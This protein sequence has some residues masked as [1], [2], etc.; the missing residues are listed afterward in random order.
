M[1]KT[2]HNHNP[3]PV[4][5]V[6]GARTV[7]VKPMHVPAWRNMG[8]SEQGEASAAQAADNKEKVAQ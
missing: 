1:T 5:M 8:Y 7:Q 3:A 6:K 4:A 2:K